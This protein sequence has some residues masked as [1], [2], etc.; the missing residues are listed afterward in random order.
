[1]CLWLETIKVN[2]GKFDNIEYHNYRFYKTRFDL[3]NIDNNL[4]LQQLVVI[5]EEYSKGLYKCRI[6]YSKDIKKIEFIKYNLPAIKTIQP[7]VCDNIEYNYK[8]KNRELINNLFQQK[9]KTDDILIV[10][11]G[12]VTDTSFCNI[13]F[14]DGTKWKTPLNPLL[15]GTKRAKLID[16][17]IIFEEEIKF[18]DINKFKK[19][20]I[21]NAMIEFEEA[22]V[23]KIV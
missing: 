7:V 14:Y 1:M 12:L 4:Y 16:E 17:K 9:G 15:K 8:S 3:L 19:I 10:K 2:N 22:M 5:P 6:E 20:C 23:E 13:A 11:N 21:F 18:Q